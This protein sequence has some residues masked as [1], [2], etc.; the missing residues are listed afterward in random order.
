MKSTGSLSEGK[1]VLWLTHCFMRSKDK[2][3]VNKVYVI[4][5]VCDSVVAL[6]WYI[7]KNHYCIAKQIKLT[8]LMEWR[9]TQV[10]F[11]KQT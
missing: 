11:P 1:K 9:Q 3:R 2:N 8:G 7:L 4:F 5:C 6:L 10:P